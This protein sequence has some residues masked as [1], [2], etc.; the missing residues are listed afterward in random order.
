[1]RSLAAGNP[2]DNHLSLWHFL[3]CCGEHFLGL[4]LEFFDFLHFF[5]FLLMR[6]PWIYGKSEFNSLSVDARQR[7]SVLRLI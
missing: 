1:M 6:S 7:A 2:N 5:S 4:H 3:T